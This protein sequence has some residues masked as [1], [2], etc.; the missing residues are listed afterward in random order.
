MK[1]PTSPH[2]TI[3]R[4]QITM[5]L[6]IL[7]RMTGVALYAGAVAMVAWLA[8]AAYYPAH[9]TGWHELANSWGG[10]VLLLGWMAAFYFHLANG[11]RHLFW[12]MGKGF[13]LPAATRS[14]WLVVVLTL[15][16]TAGSWAYATQMSEHGAK[17]S[18]RSITPREDI[19][20]D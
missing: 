11:V 8:V 3:Y 18:L 6:S 19:S 17:N 7:H 15:A 20:N 1:R 10:R 12:D 5:V 4:W 13:S 2:L 14:G 9:Y 16:L